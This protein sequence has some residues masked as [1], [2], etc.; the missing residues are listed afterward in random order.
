MVRLHNTDIKLCVSDQRLV[1]LINNFVVYPV[2]QR[3]RLALHMVLGGRE[4]KSLYGDKNLH[5]AQ[6]LEHRV[7]MSTS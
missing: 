1:N 2:K 5:V 3:M 6:R 7:I 4:F